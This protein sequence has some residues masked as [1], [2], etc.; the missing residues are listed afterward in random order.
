MAKFKNRDAES[1]KYLNINPEGVL[2]KESQ[3]IMEELKIS[4]C[5]LVLRFEIHVSFNLQSGSTNY[6]C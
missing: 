6:L 5:S 1:F 4:K 2:L 3:D